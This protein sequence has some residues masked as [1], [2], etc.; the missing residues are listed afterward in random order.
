MQGSLCLVDAPAGIPGNH[1]QCPMPLL[2]GI[3][4]ELI[5]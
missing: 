3:G 2:F 5:Q 4:M 1:Q